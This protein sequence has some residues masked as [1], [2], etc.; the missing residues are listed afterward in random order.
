[1]IAN[2]HGHIVFL[3]SLVGLIGL[4]GVADYTASKFGLTG[5]YE[6]LNL[7][8]EREGKTGVH[9]TTI[10]PYIVDTDMFDGVKIRYCS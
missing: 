4:A 5:L 1:M 6:S 3:N 2:N 8:I 9:L 10:H 7:E